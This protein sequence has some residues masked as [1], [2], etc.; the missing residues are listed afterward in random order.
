MV[1][2]VDQRCRRHG[3]NLPLASLTRV[4]ICRR[5]ADTR[6]K[7]AAGVIA[8]EVNLGKDVTNSVT[9]TGG[10]FPPL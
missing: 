1:V 5:R 7:C 10:K 8:I 3:G 9:D 2:C 4:E 6:R